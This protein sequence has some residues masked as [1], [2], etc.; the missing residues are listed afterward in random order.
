MANPLSMLFSELLS[1]QQKIYLGGSN[2]AENKEQLSIFYLSSQLQLD[3][4]LGFGNIEISIARASQLITV[5]P[6]EIKAPDEILGVT[7]QGDLKKK[8]TFRQLT[9]CWMLTFSIQCFS[10]YLSGCNLV[11]L[12]KQSHNIA[13]HM[14]YY[15]FQKF[16]QNIVWKDLHV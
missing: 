10:L 7:G 9:S 4:K 14:M 16:K 6:Y 13:L 2:N 11:V 5:F 15:L 1:Q 12:L 8:K 3:T